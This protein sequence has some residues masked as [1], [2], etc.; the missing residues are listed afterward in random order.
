MYLNYQIN[1]LLEK[2]VL[3]ISLN[4]YAF[5]V[6]CFTQQKVMLL[7]VEATATDSHGFR[8][9]FTHLSATH[10]ASVVAHSSEQHP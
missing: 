2:K 1:L 10:S 8:L 7:F 4:F 3:M 9:H 6:P 5:G